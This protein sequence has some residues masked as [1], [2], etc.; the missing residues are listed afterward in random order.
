MVIA[1]PNTGSTITM[2][3]VYNAYYV[4]GGGTPAPGTNVGLRATLGAAIG[5]SSGSITLSS[6][7][8]GRTGP[9]NYQ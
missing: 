7:F 9:Y 1:I 6:T 5:I 4:S 3:K 2:G 8:G